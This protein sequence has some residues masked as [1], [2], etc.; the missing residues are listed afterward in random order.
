[1]NTPRQTPT[2][3]Q[4][5]TDSRDRDRTGPH[6]QHC[7]QRRIAAPLRVLRTAQEAHPIPGLDPVFRALSRIYEP[8]QTIYLCVRCLCVTADPKETHDH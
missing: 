7:R 1:M 5:T 2:D 3:H 8:W 4:T 6:C